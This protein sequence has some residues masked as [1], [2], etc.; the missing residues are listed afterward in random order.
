MPSMDAAYL[1]GEGWSARKRGAMTMI[2]G[3]RILIERVLRDE[4]RKLPN[5]AIREGVSVTGLTTQD[6][7]VTGVDFGDEHID[8]DLVVDAMGR[9]SSVGGWLV[10]AGW[11]EAEVQ[12]LDAKVT[13]TSRWYELPVERPA[14]WWWQHLVIMPTPDK[15][16]HPAE[17]EFLVNFFP[18]EGNRV[19][20]CMGSWGI[21]MPRT[22]DAF[23]E[24]A[25]RVRTPLFAAAM[26]QSSP[27]SEVHL[28]RSTG[29]KWRRYDRTPVRGLVFVGDSICAFNPFY[30][31]GISSAAISALL[32]REHLSRAAS[33]NRDFYARF[34]VAQRKA[35]TVPWSLA[36]ARDQGY[37]CAVGTEQVPEWRR[38]ILA[39]VSGPAFSLI[40]GAAR[41]Y[42]V[43][44][45]HFAKVFNLDESLGEMMKN[46]RVLAAL[47]RYRFRKALGRHRVPFGF[48]PQAE[49]P[50]TDY[51]QSLAAAR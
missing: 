9:G 17:H 40:V 10:A 25:R 1:D 15:G 35:L 41:E 28:T 6:H 44:D 51:S 30:G 13:Y 3:S 11:P 8:A 22:T 4:V 29:N 2:Y 47:V 21:E 49:P 14:S 20:A 33:L 26:D 34:L 5:T 38:R 18:I 12:T 7:A 45:E 39:A 16:K 42:E 23:I 36:M 27:I 31:Q 50:A 48:D 46:P 43:V 37:E 24:S 32:L 19:I